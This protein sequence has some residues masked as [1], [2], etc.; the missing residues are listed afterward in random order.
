MSVQKTDL[1]GVLLIKPERFG[2]HRGFLLKPI[3]NNCMVGLEPMPISSEVMT[4]FRRS[5]VL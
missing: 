3:V 2:N 4:H 5:W 1:A